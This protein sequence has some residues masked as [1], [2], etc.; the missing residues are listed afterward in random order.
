MRA[1]RLAIKLDLK[2]KRTCLSICLSI[3]LHLVGMVLVFV[4]RVK[5]FVNYLVRARYWR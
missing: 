2:K 4:L 5:V 3:K 1:M